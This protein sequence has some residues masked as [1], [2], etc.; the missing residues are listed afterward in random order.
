MSV[1]RKYACNFSNIS[2][3]SSSDSEGVVL[4]DCGRAA[5]V[6]ADVSVEASAAAAGA[7]DGADDMP[8][9]DRF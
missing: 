9:P 2:I 3:V 5:V 1:A 4:S 7:F 6:G 8:V